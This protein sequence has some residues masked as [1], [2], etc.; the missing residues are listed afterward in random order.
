LFG[1][2]GSFTVNVRVSDGD[3]GSDIDST[4]V[5]VINV[6]PTISDTSN[7]GPINEGG[8]ATITVTA[9]D[10]AGAND[11]LSYE[12]DCD[13]DATYEVGPQAGNSTSCSFAN[14]G[15]FTVNV[16]VMDGDGGADTDSTTVTVDNVAPVVSAGAD[17]TINEGSTFTSGGSFTDPGADTWTA[18]VDYGDGSGSQALTLAM[19][20]TFALSHAYAQDGVFTVTVTVNDDDTS[21]SDTLIVTVNNV[22]PVVSAFSCTPNPVAEGT[23]TSCTVNFTDAGTLDT[24][25]CAVD[26]DDG[27]TDPAVTCASGD[28]FSHTYAD[29]DGT[30]FTAKV[31][32]TDDGN[33]SDDETSSVTVT[34]VAPVVSAFTCT[35]NPVAEGASTSCSVT[36]AD[37]GTEDTH[38]CALDWG[39]GDTDAAVACV[40]G[41]SFS[42]TYA[43]DDGGPFSA[44]VTV[45]DDDT[46]AD[47]ETTNVAVTNV[48][49]VV[50]A[51]TCTPNP[52]TEG[53]SMSC[54]VSFTDAGTL[55]THTCAVDWGDGNTAAAVA[56]ETGDSFSHTYVDDDGGPFSAKV[57]VTDDDTGADDETASLTVTNAL[58]VVAA[59]VDQTA[60]IGDLVTINPSLTDAGVN[61]N[62]WTVTIDW[63]DGT[64]L[65]S[66]NVATQGAIPAQSHTYAAI[67]VYTVEVCVTDKDGGEGC[68]TLSVDIN[69]PF[70][71]FF[72]PVDNMPKVNQ[73]KAGSAIRHG[74]P[75]VLPDALPVFHSS[76]EHQR[77][78]GIGDTPG[79]AGRRHGP[80]GRQLVALQQ[81]QRAVQLR[82]ED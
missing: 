12:F 11:P 20:K 2:N 67:G 52:V 61:D 64:P 31:T 46:G 50:S 37:A 78:L 62:P 5:I 82:L 70:D 75:A 55:D 51:L 27:D 39:D 29:D 53:T 25:T 47:D 13:N 34:N 26:W 49:P 3:G 22:A 65:V 68:D 45:T 72:S 28:A 71:G 41:A 10:P 42:H 73:V 59:G 24:H 81:R 36:F 66:F 19:D 80:S 63:D 43:D 8:S 60:E 16:R 32:V 14:D 38:T 57:T 48:A 7:N 15:S 44:K 35:P 69:F 56:C 9:T 17:N 58:P 21:G 4:T 79:D 74:Q 40:T 30:P 23:S 33:D 1:D 77:H 76:G 6:D 54:T 18:T